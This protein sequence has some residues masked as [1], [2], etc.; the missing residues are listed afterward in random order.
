MM[1]RHNK[2]YEKIRFVKFWVNGKAGNLISLCP[3]CFKEA[4][5]HNIGK[6]KLIKPELIIVIKKAKINIKLN[7]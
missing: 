1:D 3:C 2:I 7:S 4:R 6:I 5:K